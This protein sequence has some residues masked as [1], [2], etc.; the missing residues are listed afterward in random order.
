MNKSVLVIIAY[1]QKPTLIIH[2]DVS[3]GARSL[4]VGL[5]LLLLC[6]FFVDARGKGSDET[7]S[8]CRFGSS[9]SLLFTNG[10]NTKIRY[11]FKF[12]SMLFSSTFKCVNIQ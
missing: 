5:I 1:A 12:F 3:S 7:A 10:I 8:M 11:Y 4:C 6:S 9:E 2:S